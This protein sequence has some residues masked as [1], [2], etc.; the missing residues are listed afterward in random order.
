MDFYV[1]PEDVSL[2]D[3]KAIDEARS[4]PELV[5]HIMR[6]TGV[7]EEEAY[8]IKPRDLR[9]FRASLKAAWTEASEIP[10]EPEPSRTPSQPSATAAKRRRRS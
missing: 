6:L 3:M 1:D 2:G 7:T 5:G 8:S 9:A 10:N 4:I